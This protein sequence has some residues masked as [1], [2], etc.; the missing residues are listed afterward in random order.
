MDTDSSGLASEAAPGAAGVWD[1][2]AAAAC[3]SELSLRALTSRWIGSDAAMAVFGGGNT[4]VKGPWPARGDPSEPCLYVKGT[5]ADLAEVT[6]A[7]FTPIRLRAAA[8]LLRGPALDNVALMQ[9]LDPIKLDRDAPRPSIET[10]LHAALPHKFVEHTHADAILAVINTASGPDTARRLFGTKAPLVPFRHSGF[11][12]AAACAEVYDREH[13]GDTIGLLLAFHGVVAFGNDARESHRNLYELRAIAERHLRDRGA[14]TLATGPT[15]RRTWERAVALA[16]LRLALS[17]TAGFPMVLH[18]DD[19]AE[20]M[21]FVA[22]TDLARIA[23]QG[24]PTPQHAVFTKRLPALGLDVDAYARDYVVYRQQ[25]GAAYP[26]D[27]RPDPAPRVLLDPAY[28]A[29]AASIDGR[30]ANMTSTV[31]RHDIDIIS[32]ASAHN[33]Y[34]SLPPEAVLAAEVHY[35]GFERARLARRAADLPLLGCIVAIGGGQTLSWSPL[36]RALR[37][38]GADV[39]ALGP[40]QDATAGVYRHGGI[41]IFLCPH[42]GVSPGSQVELLLEYSP[43]G[44][45]VLSPSPEA[46][47]EDIVETAALVWASVPGAPA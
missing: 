11:D 2:A 15:P 14:W 44:G 27:L 45:L 26:A 6:E 1:D 36:A 31:Y 28:G 20:T 35:G 5:G 22:R 30:H 40:E 3:S 18:V 43:G 29:I 33:D 32:R 10:L 41:D 4:S 25:F 38:A 16:G 7:D 23:L 17:R 39:F 21:G 12:L 42:P 9:A 34:V 8:A 46:D 13:S 47:V 37:A 19:C 24:P